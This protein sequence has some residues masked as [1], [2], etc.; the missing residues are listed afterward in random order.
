MVVSVILTNFKY[1]QY[2]YQAIKSAVNACT[3]ADV[4]HQIIVVTDDP[5]SNFDHGLKNDKNMGVAYSRNRGI[6]ESRGD[7]IVILDGD[8]MLTPDSI[9]NQLTIMSMGDVDMVHGPVYRFE[10]D[11]N[12]K[13]CLSSQFKKH[14]SL[15]TCQGMMVK[16]EVFE[17]RGL[18]FEGLRSA[19]DKEMLYRWG[20]HRNSPIS[21]NIN[22]IRINKPV[23]YYRRHPGSKR[24]K[25]K[26]DLNFDIQTMMAFD[27]RVM[28]MVQNGI[29]AG[30]E[31]LPKR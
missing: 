5:E 17:T 30:I 26:Y 12:Y 10:G 11:L 28:D 18:Y 31:L 27:A 22:A 7:Y 29:T 24:K 6:K 13:D 4:V 20:L 21:K 15:I 19:E 1:E 3:R 8:D 25:R 2:I 9:K 23:A 14:P 16:R